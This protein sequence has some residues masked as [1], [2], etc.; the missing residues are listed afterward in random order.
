[1]RKSLVTFLLALFV[2]L[3]AQG[4]DLLVAASANT[5][6]VVKELAAVF[7]M[8]TG[9]R[10][11]VSIAASGTICSQ[12]INGAPF[13]VFLS[14]DTQY[15]RRLEQAGFVRPGSLTVYAVGRLVLWS[16]SQSGVDV[17]RLQMK[18]LVSPKVRK[19]AIA[20]P[21]HAPYGQ[22]A[23]QALRHFGLEQAIK[24][25]LVLGENVTQVLQFVESGAAEAGFVPL[26]LILR[27]SE[28]RRGTMWA[29]P[30]E[31]HAPLRQAAVILKGG[32]ARPEIARQ[33]LDFLKGEEGERLLRKYGY[34]LP[35]DRQGNRP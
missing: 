31:S 19:V 18:A 8:R 33:F 29:I 20:N 10:L 32:K 35:E 1:V 26:S 7:G 30:E 21:R 16:G 12:V 6:G 5:S 23:I 9:H 2:W 4:A 34:S 27:F 24:P 13:D 25:K 11:R 14:A 17:S 28:S 15:P 22:G 3:P